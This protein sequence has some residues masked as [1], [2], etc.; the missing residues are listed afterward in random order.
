MGGAY[1]CSLPVFGANAFIIFDSPTQR[2][3]QIAGTC[4]FAGTSYPLVNE[5]TRGSR[6]LFTI[7]GVLLYIPI[8]LR[9]HKV[10]QA[11]GQ[12][13]QL[14]LS[15]RKKL[16]RYNIIVSI[17][18]INEIILIVIPDT[19]LVVWPV[20]MDKIR[21]PLSIMTIFKSKKI[22]VLYKAI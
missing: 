17:M 2:D 8:T 22:C 18:V 16:I 20:Q 21:Y 9:T 3:F 10:Y 19:L 7:V 11:K 12:Y 1:L 4:E 14:K 5:I 15:Q 13:A 6:A